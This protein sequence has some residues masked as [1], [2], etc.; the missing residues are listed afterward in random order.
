M[1]KTSLLIALTVALFSLAVVPLA[2]GKM[3]TWE[4]RN[5]KI[6]R[7][8]YPPPANQV[9]TQSPQARSSRQQAV[10]SQRVELYVTSWCPYCKKAEEFFRS[11]GIATTIYDIEKD[12][13]AAASKNR[14]DNKKGVP[15]AIVN[16]RKIH[17]YAPE[18][19]ES[20]LKE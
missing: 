11:R 4:D 14:L 5:G 8:Y 19:Y 13:K 6:R 2:S 7:T 1:K 17:G 18:Q 20:A 12:K 9:K 16:G 10:K 3:Y 15:F